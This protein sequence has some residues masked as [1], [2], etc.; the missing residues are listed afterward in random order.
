MADKLFSSFIKKQ[1]PQ[2]QVSHAVSEMIVLIIICFDV[3]EMVR[4]G[5]VPSSSKSRMKRVIATDGTKDGLTGICIFF[6]RP[7]N[8][9]AVTSANIANELHCGQLDARGGLSLLQVVREY[10]QLVMLP[11]LQQGQNW[12]NLQ[13]K[14]V[15]VFMSTFKTYINFLQSKTVA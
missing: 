3:G 13:E 1:K 2:F 4:W 14:Q 10:M 6:I 15:D 8:A 12:G 11:A 9:K 7:R 5:I